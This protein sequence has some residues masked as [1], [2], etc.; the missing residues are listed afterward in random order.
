M[1]RIYAVR[2]NQRR[3]R[4]G[5]LWHSRFSTVA[6]DGP[7]LAAAFAYVTLNPVRA[8]LAASAREWAWSSAG[9]YLAKKND[10]VTD[11]A[12]MR[13]LAENPAALLKAPDAEAMERLRKAE[14]IGRPVGGEKFIARLEKKTGRILKPQKRGPKPKL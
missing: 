2:F 4:E 9:A 8:K 3:K 7:H 11:V 10:G 13:A 1:N 5:K 6:M 14:R 12:A